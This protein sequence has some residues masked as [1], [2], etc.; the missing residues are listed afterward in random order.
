MRYLNWRISG[1]PENKC[2]RLPSVAEKEQVE[3]F[4]GLILP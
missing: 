2:E 1:L 3:W 4:V